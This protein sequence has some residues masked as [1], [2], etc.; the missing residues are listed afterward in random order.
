MTISCIATIYNSNAFLMNNF[1][2]GYELQRPETQLDVTNCEIRKLGT[3]RRD[4]LELLSLK[5]KITAIIVVSPEFVA[6]LFYQ[7]SDTIPPKKHHDDDN[8]DAWWA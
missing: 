3:K 5:I 7:Q 4:S 6:N 1:F 2:A 8:D